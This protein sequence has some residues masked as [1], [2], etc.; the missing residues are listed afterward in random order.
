MGMN[1]KELHLMTENMKLMQSKHQRKEQQDEIDAEKQQLIEDEFQIKQMIKE[2]EIRKKRLEEKQKKVSSTKKEIESKEFELNAK[3]KEFEREKNI[4]SKFEEL[5]NEQRKKNVANIL[6]QIKKE[7]VKRNKLNKELKRSLSKKGM[8]IWCGTMKENELMI[9]QMVNEIVSNADDEKNECQQQ[10]QEDAMLFDL[11]QIDS[12][13]D[14]GF[15]IEHVLF[16]QDIE[17]DDDEDDDDSD[18]E[19][20]EEMKDNN[21]TA[22]SPSNEC[23]NVP[24]VDDTQSNSTPIQDEE[25]T[26]HSFDED[27]VNE[28]D[29]A[30]NQTNDEGIGNSKETIGRKAKKSKPQK[31][32]LNQK[33]WS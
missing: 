5:V 4:K 3:R 20:K 8:D 19:S 24:Q 2:L 30:Q 13:I 11:N 14:D 26:T 23:L 33:N 9:H 12:L 25:D 1:K 32:K 16:N 28:I 17:E 31:K 22:S 7:K 18:D 27:D 21:L 6:R 29:D 15:S 10:Q